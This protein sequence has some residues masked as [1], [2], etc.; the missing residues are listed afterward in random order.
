MMELSPARCIFKKLTHEIASVLVI[1]DRCDKSRELSGH[2]NHS[3][4][5]QQLDDQKMY[6]EIVPW[7]HEKHLFFF[8]DP[9][10]MSIFFLT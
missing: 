3:D 9:K 6:L 5:W 1:I 10:A 8:R 4:Q 2:E 7:N